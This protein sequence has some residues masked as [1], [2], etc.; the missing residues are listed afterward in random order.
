ME[1][2][3]P[4]KVGDRV[5]VQSGTSQYNGKIGT[6]IYKKDLDSN[7]KVK[8]DDDSVELTFSLKYITIVPEQQQKKRQ[9]ETSSVRSTL[10]FSSFSNVLYPT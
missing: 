4:I 3:K 7:C 8:F 1:E 6:V 10:F 5:I 2:P 9:R